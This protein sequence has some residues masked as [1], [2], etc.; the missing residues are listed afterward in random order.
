MLSITDTNVPTVPI[1]SKTFRPQYQLGLQTPEQ[2]STS[3][4]H[5]WIDSRHLLL[6]DTTFCQLCVS[7]LHSQNRD[8]A[9]ILNRCSNWEDAR[10]FYFWKPDSPKWHQGSVLKVLGQQTC[11][12]IYQRNMLKK[13]V[14]I[15]TL[16]SIQFLTR[17]W[18][19]CSKQFVVKT[20]DIWSK[21]H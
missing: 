19:V 4:W 1:Q 7:Q 8:E 13:K 15:V 9:C 11:K 14:L 20:T 21:T 17:Q 10:V 6:Y 3:V 16:S 5:S 12:N 18:I 2:R